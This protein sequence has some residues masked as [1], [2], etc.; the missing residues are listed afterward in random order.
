MTLS[1]TWWIWISCFLNWKLFF[2]RFVIWL[3]Y[4]R[5]FNLFV[6][7]EDFTVCSNTEDGEREILRENG[8]LKS[9]ILLLGSQLEEKDRK[10][11]NLENEI[12]RKR[13]NTCST[14][15]QTA[16]WNTPAKVTGHNPRAR[17]RQTQLIVPTFFL[18]VIL[19]T[20]HSLPMESSDWDPKS[21]ITTCT[22]MIYTLK[23]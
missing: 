18:S 11:R 19:L 5:H 2:Y 20:R 21:H 10:I 4:L 15:S 23:K 9:H 17:S 14:S 12:R 7:T 1:K 6:Q 22:V 8:E 16:E 3:H 13:V